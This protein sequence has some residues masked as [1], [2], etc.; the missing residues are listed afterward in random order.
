[1]DKQKNYTLHEAIKEMFDLEDYSPE[2]KEKML[3]ETAGMVMEGTILRMLAESDEQTQEKFAKFTETNPQE[4][5]MTQF[6]EENFPTFSQVMID[7]LKILKSL[8]KE[9][10]NN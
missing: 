2:E 1:M 3:N 9:S 4:D 8:G 6:I 5:E 10:K 7:E